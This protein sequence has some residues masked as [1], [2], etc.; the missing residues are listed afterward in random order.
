MT[1]YLQTAGL[2]ILL[3]ILYATYRSRVQWLK[4]R[5]ELTALQRH[6]LEQMVTALHGARA[7]MEADLVELRELRGRPV[8]HQH[9]IV[10]LEPAVVTQ[11]LRLVRAA[12]RL[13]GASIPSTVSRQPTPEEVAEKGARAEAINIGVATLRSQYE[14]IGIAR[15]DA[16]LREEATA[17]LDGITSEQVSNLLFT[18]GG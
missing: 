17:M 4:E 7:E 5:A 2:L 14:G 9:A 10:A 15:T 12:Q 3:V 13:P 1:F 8:V 11:L 6:T 18:P 16:E